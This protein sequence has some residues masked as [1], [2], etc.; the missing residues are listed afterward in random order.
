MPI[1]LTKRLSVMTNH[2]LIRDKDKAALLQLLTCYLPEVTTWAYG[3]RVNGMAH[4]TSDL[5]LVLLSRDLSPIP[6]LVLDDFVA[7]LRES[8]IP[9]L[10]EAR[11]WARLPVSFHQE[12]LKNYV[13]IREAEPE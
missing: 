9:I 7:A 5:D 8:N 4:D 13:V 6:F 11:D 12:I 3:S 1:E 2:L 10:I